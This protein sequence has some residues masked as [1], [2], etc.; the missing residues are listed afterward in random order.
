MCNLP[1]WQ[2]SALVIGAI[3][4]ALVD[5]ASAAEQPN[6]RALLD[7]DD[8]LIVDTE[9]T[10]L[11]RRAEI[12]EI[13]IIDTTGTVRF[14]SLS[15]PQG[16]I[17]SEASDLHRL[18]RLVLRSKGAKPWP[19]IHGA[20]VD[21]L[22]D[23]AVVLAW[24]APFDARMLSQTASRYGL[25]VRSVPWRD[26]LADY[27]RLRPG[28]RHS[29]RVAG[30]RE[31]VAV[32]GPVH[33]ALLD[34]RTVLAIMR[35]VVGWRS[36]FKPRMADRRARLRTRDPGPRLAAL[37]RRTRMAA[38]RGFGKPAARSWAGI[39][40]AYLISTIIHNHILIARQYL[41]PFIKKGYLLIRETP[42][43][44][45]SSCPDSFRASRPGLGR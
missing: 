9:T 18:T 28:G 29:L 21:A 40:R 14:E 43:P 4:F 45:P 22:K 23:A 7:R 24:N 10:G 32:E 31:G 3:L 12:L 37:N 39:P 8:V 35:R 25:S 1:A 42:P 26:A 30:K 33:R 38:Y 20:V 11:G 41:F 44:P 16:R 6:W 34:C 36:R 17:P 27:R 13:A 2:W 19:D 5:A 15:L